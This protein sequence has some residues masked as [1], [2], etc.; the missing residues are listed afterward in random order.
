MSAGIFVLIPIFDGRIV[1]FPKGDSLLLSGKFPSFA[2][3]VAISPNFL[4]EL[5]SVPSSPAYTQPR[6][7]PGSGSFLKTMSPTL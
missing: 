1:K 3:S 2:L 5:S 7:P 6:Y 4:Q